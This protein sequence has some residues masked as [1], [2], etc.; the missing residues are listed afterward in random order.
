M[1]PVVDLTAATSYAKQNPAA[2]I[3]TVLVLL[4]GVYG[5]Y[6]VTK[7]YPKAKNKILLAIFCAY[8]GFGVWL[9]WQ[10]FEPQ[11]SPVSKVQAA[12]QNYQEKIQGFDV[13]LLNK[14]DDPQPDDRVSFKETQ[15]DQ[16]IYHGKIIEP[17][18]ATLNRKRCS[19]G[20]MVM[21]DA[22][23]PLNTRGTG[24]QINHFKAFIKVKEG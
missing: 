16:C 21:Q 9:N 13:V 20:I 18:T 22:I 1:I 12:A 10:M 17:G 24:D 14:N 11:P 8:V 19:D 2:T 5:F 7:K 4:L 15:G 6:W 3:A 23:V